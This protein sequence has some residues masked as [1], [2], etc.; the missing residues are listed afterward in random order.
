LYQKG[1]KRKEEQLRMLKEVRTL[2]ER[3]EL[4]KECR[5][6]PQIN[7]ISRMIAHPLR[8]EGVKPEE[9]LIKYGQQ[10]REKLEKIRSD[11]LF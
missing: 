3:E 2:K 7:E 8:S 1:I 10:Q 4:A 11:L 9:A 5:F 6:H